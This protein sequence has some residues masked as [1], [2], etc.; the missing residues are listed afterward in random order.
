MR[1]DATEVDINIALEHRAGAGSKSKRTAATHAH[2]M[3]SGHDKCAAD[4][5]ISDEYLLQ[6]ETGNV[7]RVWTGRE[8]EHTRGSTI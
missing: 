6:V 2:T 4:D 5:C 3:D 1:G 8:R 7:Q